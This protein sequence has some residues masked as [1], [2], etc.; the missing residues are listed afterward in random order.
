[1]L[2]QSS[3]S[4][5]EFILDSRIEAA[6]FKVVDLALC[7]VRLMDDE[8]FPWLLLVPQQA[9]AEEWTDLSQANQHVLADEIAAVVSAVRSLFEPDKMNIATLGNQVRQLHVHVIARNT[10]DAAWPDAVWCH[11]QPSPY[12]EATRIS[13]IESLGSSLGI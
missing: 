7:Q 11:G 2:S 10:D 13:T 5:S 1:M 9:G 3:S 12:T 6:S 8:R 4:N